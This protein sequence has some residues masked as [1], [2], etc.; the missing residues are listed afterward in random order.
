[1][2]MQ[3]TVSIYTLISTVYYITKGTITLYTESGNP[4]IKYK[5][6]DTV[7]DSDTLLNVQY[8]L[9]ISSLET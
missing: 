8:N 3:K 9:V 7:G 1:M 5:D 2:I 4:F 6:G